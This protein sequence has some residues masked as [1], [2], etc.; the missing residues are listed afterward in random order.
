MAEEAHHPWR[1]RGRFY[2]LPTSWR[3][4]ALEMAPT[5]DA[6]GRAQ[7]CLVSRLGRHPPS[8]VFVAMLLVCLLSSSGDA[9][10]AKFKSKVAA[11]RP[12]AAKRR[13]LSEWS[14]PPICGTAVVVE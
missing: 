10:M 2:Q 7:A 6:E 8:P 9:C 12:R 1:R 11:C 5:V 3:V 4:A 13:G 14:Q